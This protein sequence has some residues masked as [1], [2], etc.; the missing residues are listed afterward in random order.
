[1]KGMIGT[2]AMTAAGVI[3]LVLPM[4]DFTRQDKIAMLLAI[5]AMIFLFITDWNSWVDPV[6]EDEES[7]REMLSMTTLPGKRHTLR[8][9][10]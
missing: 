2:F 6:E 3:C 4:D 5:G 10:E 1:M 9:N 7:F 8:D